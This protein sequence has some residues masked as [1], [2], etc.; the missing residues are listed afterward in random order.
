MLHAGRYAW[1]VLG[2]L[3]LA[4]AVGF[5]AGRLSLLVVPLVLALF[6]A[7]VLGP[8]TAVLRR[9]RVPPGLAALVTVL[10]G[11]ALVAAVVAGL[12]P[13]VAAELPTLGESLGEGLTDLRRLLDR[14]PVQV[15]A[16]GELLD[17]A[18]EQVGEAVGP[19]VQAATAVLETVVGVI[20]GLVVLFFYLKDGD[21]IA[22]ALG[23][24]V[25]SRVRED[26][27]VVSARAWETVGSYFRGQLLIAL[28]D[29]VLIGIGLV[30]LGVPLALPLAALVFF[31]ALFPIVGAFVSGFV[32]VV[33]ALAH[34]G[35]VLALAVLALIVVVQQLE[36]NVLQPYVLSKVVALHPL[37]VLVA[38]TGGALTLGVLGAFLAVPVAA[39]T[40][41]AVEYVRRERAGARA[42]R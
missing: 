15:P 4:V 23:G 21:R 22:R 32:A 29:A 30:V 27:S 11:L 28:V 7:A 18:A 35:P 12:V 10:G 14:L 13:L 39:S 20:F 36:G 9:H 41:R 6:P 37:V 2:L 5:V 1:A 38:I 3:G 24:F 25:P 16:T 40:A 19:A 42:A 8:A 31:G 17:R 26:V 34:G 33:V